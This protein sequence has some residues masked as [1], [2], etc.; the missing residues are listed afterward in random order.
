[1]QSED[2]RK[3][4]P[5]HRRLATSGEESNTSLSKR[6]IS[7]P[8]FLCPGQSQP[9]T[10]AVHLARLNAAWSVCD[11][12]E[13]RHHSE[14]LATSTIEQ[15][16]RIRD[17]RVDGLRRTEF[18]IRGPYINALNRSVAAD[19]ARVFCS[20]FADSDLFGT[21]RTDHACEEA[22][23]RRATAMLRTLQSP[24]DP[25]SPESSLLTVPVMDEI[26]PI[27]IGYDSRHSS[28]D[29][30]AGTLAAVREFGIPV[31]DIGRC[32]TA[33]LQAFVRSDE[34]CCGSLI[35]TGAGMPPSWNGI[36]AMDAEGDPVPVVWKDF[37]I[38]LHHVASHETSTLAATERTISRDDQANE[39]S[40]VDEMLRRIRGE[41]TRSTASDDAFTQKTPTITQ[42][43]QAMS[44]QLRIDLPEQEIRQRWMRRL[45]RESG[46]H[47]VV[48]FE[49]TYREGLLRWYPSRGESRILVRSD[50]EMI[51]ER[52]EWLRAQTGLEL[53]CRGFKDDAD[54]P[55]CRFSMV[56][57]EDDRNFQLAGRRGELI[58]SERLALMINRAIQSA[59]SHVT[60]HADD[61]T[62][63]FWLSDSARSGA[64]LMTDRIRDS[65]VVLG[66]VARLTEAA[67][68]NFG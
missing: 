52:I 2:T 37:S 38:R 55:A 17:H 39:D 1:M 19:F 60:A 44:R 10:R 7:E 32:T 20:C 3:D 54:I 28:P 51:H 41:L 15:T 8:S 22:L 12:C 9:V 56:I 34:S 59:A 53:I 62:G 50:D 42:P 65:L 26:A 31:L 68:I 27:A 64:R 61:V 4:L 16:E 11:E 40:A 29:L 66:L 46:S 33:S 23:Q 48:A 35:V 18:G 36:D 58:S 47:H 43:G 57:E 67:Q 6:P 63:R 25:K 14:G 13:W 49:Q 21:S 30:F 24:A 5:E 45:R